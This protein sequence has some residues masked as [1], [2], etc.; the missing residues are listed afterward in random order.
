[1][2][3]DA[4]SFLSVIPG[5]DPLFDDITIYLDAAA[6]TSADIGEYMV[7][8]TVEFLDFPLRPKLQEEFK[9]TLKYN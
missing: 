1:M 5:A 8:Y 9:F 3:E 4:P 7:G 2:N 6:L